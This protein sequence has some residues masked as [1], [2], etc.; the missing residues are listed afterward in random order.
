MIQVFADGVMVYDSRL[1]DYELVGLKRTGGLNKGGTAEITMPADHPA[2]NSFTGYKT[3]V[4]IYRDGRL[5]FR[6]RALYPLDD[7]YRR[8]TVV[9]EGELCFFQDGI[10]RPYLYETS[11]EEI[12]SAVVADY[13]SQVEPFKRFRLGTVTVQDANDYLRLESEGAETCLATLN[14]LLERCGGYIT[15]TTAEDGA[16]V[17]NWLASVG[18]R[19]GQTIELGENLFDFTRSGANTDLATALVPY[20]A[21]TET[22]RVTIKDVNGGKDYIVDTAAAAIR[23]T[24]FK[25]VTWDD[26]TEPENLLRKAR[27]YLD[28]CKL[29]VTSLELTALDLSY[30]DKTLDCF[31]EGDW[32]RVVS[33]AHGLD[34]DFQITDRSENMLN[35]KDGLLKMGKEIRSLTSQ[36][37]AG[38]KK[39]QS[40]LEKATQSIKKDYEINIKQVAAEVVGEQMSS[41]IKQAHDSILMEVSTLYASRAYVASSIKTLADGIT[42]KTEGSLGDEATIKLTVNGATITETMDLSKVRQAFAGDT[43]AV[44]ISAGTVTFS[45]GTLIINSTNLQV[46]ADGT[47]KA[48]NAELTG[49]ATTENGLYKSELSGGRLRFLYEGEEYGGIA[50]SYMDGDETV[51][52]V[53]VRLSEQAK[54]MGFSRLDSETGL[55][56]LYYGIN[57]GANVGG[58]TER[59]L[60]FGSAY[61]SDS[62]LVAGALN[63]NGA[64]SF[65]GAVYYYNNA[66]FTQAATFSTTTTFNGAV[67]HN[68]NA[69]FANGK[70]VALYT[71]DG[72]TVF[73]MTV[74]SDDNLY[75]GSTSIPVYVVG[76]SVQVG[77]SSCPTTITGSSVA[78]NNSV[79]ITGAVTLN[80]G[81]GL[82]V[83]DS[84]GTA[85]YVVSLSNTD[86]MSV[87]N[88][89]FTLNLRGAGVTVPFGNVVLTQGS[90]ML[91]NGYGIVTYD[92]SG[93]SQYILSLNTGN[94][95]CVGSSN[96]VTYLR[97]T[98]VYL[99][100]S[101][102]A[103]TSD[104][105][106]KNSVEALPDAYEA[107]IDK[108]TPVRYK[109][110]DGTSGRY[111]A[112]FIAQ[113]VQEALESVGLTTQDF[114]G[115]IDLNGD[116]EELGLIYSEFIALLLHKI[117]HQEQRIAALEERG[118]T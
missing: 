44:E 1:E 90:I 57:F 92:T 64:T 25:T 89:N 93:A 6:G 75:L 52:G 7:F 42:L 45:S 4:E 39:A 100:S 115:F 99:A 58:R 43:S 26:V 79:A 2:Y 70:G 82:R 40:D 41:E 9:C 72:K 54:Y 112:G 55:Y 105:R 60:F 35:P 87:G 88:A 49:T 15:F 34:E 31:E 8:R 81:Y 68:A 21:Q 62:V 38:D 101:G 30:V 13:N 22:G 111:H 118:T 61:F 5:K 20:G 84:A 46:S 24:I 50:S 69:F 29:V 14:K 63:V 95:V 56:D 96:H 102:A 78:I 3:I 66:Y 116:G 98:A 36:D 16:R 83:K 37:V 110:N 53:T 108:L 32:V 117:K 86:Q 10:S 18:N 73:S 33:R 47:I 103:V 51:R 27:Q 104:A 59:H 48:T 76:S 94:Q 65:L 71:T 109:Y 113:E 28:E 91:A 12:F 97:G 85:H 80:N 74:Q 11:P 106:K 67:V 114:G 17:I 19:V 23:G 77:T 107:L